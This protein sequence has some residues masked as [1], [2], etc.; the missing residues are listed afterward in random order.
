MKYHVL[1]TSQLKGQ[2]P[3]SHSRIN[4]VKLLM[5]R[6]IGEYVNTMIFLETRSS[7]VAERP[8]KWRDALSLK[9]L[10]LLKITQDH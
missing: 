2:R 1:R 3:T 4:A 10:L 5:N 6:R 9:I 7:A 8:R